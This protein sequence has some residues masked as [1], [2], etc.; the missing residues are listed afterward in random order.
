MNPQHATRTPVKQ[1]DVLRAS[2]LAELTRVR[3]FA[4]MLQVDREILE[5]LE[6]PEWLKFLFPYERRDQATLTPTEQE[7]F[8]SAYN[9]INANGTVGKLVDT[10]AEMH[11]QHTNDRLLPW[12]RVFLLVFEHALRA[13]HPDV[14]I[15]YWDWTQPGEESVPPWLVG[16]TPTVV[17]PTRTIHV[18][19]APGTTSDLATIASNV[20]SILAMDDF[21]DF[22]MN[23]NAVHG[24]VHIWVGGSMSLVSDSPSDPIFWMHHANLDRLWWVWHS[25]SGHGG[26]NP[27]LSGTSANMDPWWP[28]YAEPETRDIEALGYVYA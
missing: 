10:H 27:P 26:E 3:T 2:S 19:R 17:T 15:P 21:E 4:V 16:V 5:A 9:V 25:E 24:S 13:V 12:H 23:M 6:L 20:P 14:T 11:M 1:R 8:L 28:P 7:R 22:A 18:T